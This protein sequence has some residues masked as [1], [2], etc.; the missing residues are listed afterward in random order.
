MKEYRLRHIKSNEMLGFYTDS[1]EGG[2]F[3]Y[4]VQY[5][6]DTG[7]DNFW[8]VDTPE[9][10]EWVRLNSTRWYNADYSTPTHYYKPEELEVVGVIVE[11]KEIKVQLPTLLEYY[12]WKANKDKGY[13]NILKEYTERGRD[14]NISYFQMTEYIRGN[15]DV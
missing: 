15:S 9:H 3:C 6:L 7:R 12:T 2:D 14:E 4:D 1:N 5:I 11:I 8:S 10:A 13:K